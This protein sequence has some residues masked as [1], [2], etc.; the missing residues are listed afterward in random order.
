MNSQINTSPVPWEWSLPNKALQAG[1]QSPSLPWAT[2][3]AHQE[4][5]RRPSCWDGTPGPRCPHSALH[6]AE[7]VSLM[8]HWCCLTLGIWGTLLS[9]DVFVYNQATHCSDYKDRFSCRLL[10]NTAFLVTALQRYIIG[11]FCS[12]KGFWLLVQKEIKWNLDFFSPLLLKAVF[13]SH[14]EINWDR[15]LFSS[16]L[17]NMDD[18]LFPHFAFKYPVI[19]VVCFAQLFSQLHTAPAV[20]TQ[21]VLC[22]S[23]ALSV[24]PLINR[25]LWPLHI[26]YFTYLADMCNLQRQPFFDHHFLDSKRLH[27]PGKTKKHVIPFQAFTIIEAHS[28][29][30]LP[31][32][33]AK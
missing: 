19:L 12:L 15:N 5:S 21:E 3:P 29:F 10:E 27:Y 7:D 11:S 14:R 26:T 23:S 31:F 30:G 4:S 1:V 18:S 13:I 28:D 33:F 22:G 9:T 6:T 8:F 24:H 20:M 32:K 2:S 16:T 25:A 17:I